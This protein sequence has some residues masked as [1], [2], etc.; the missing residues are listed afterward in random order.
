MRCLLV[1]LMMSLMVWG[2]ALAQDA[3][4]DQGK[5]AAAPAAPATQAQPAGKSEVTGLPIYQG[6]EYQSLESNKLD[7]HNIPP[8][9]HA[10]QQRPVE[11]VGYSPLTLADFIGLDVCLDIMNVLYHGLGDPKYRPCPLLRKYVAQGWL[12]RKAGRG[13]YTY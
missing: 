4:A 1:G 12:G 7:I 3:P 6:P 5:E 13:F 11:E 10:F 9:F 2:V 8:E